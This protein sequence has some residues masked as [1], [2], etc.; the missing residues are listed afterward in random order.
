MLRC[1][2]LQAG[3]FP[4]RGYLLTNRFRHLNLVWRWDGREAYELISTSKAL[5]HLIEKSVVVEGVLV[6]LRGFGRCLNPSVLLLL[7]GALNLNLGC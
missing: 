7:G 3:T 2:T 4:H 5:C 6:P 1:K